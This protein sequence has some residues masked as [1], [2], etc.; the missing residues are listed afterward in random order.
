MTAE[1]RNNG[2]TLVEVLVAVVLI[3]I[4]FAVLAA[5]QV[6]SLASFVS[7]MDYSAEVSVDHD[8]DVATPEVLEAQT[9]TIRVPGVC[10]P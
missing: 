2:L 8:N 10:A 6:S 5:T 1:A 9:P 3:A 7:C 4:V